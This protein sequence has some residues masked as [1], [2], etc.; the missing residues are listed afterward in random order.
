MFQHENFLLGQMPEFAPGQIFFGEAGIINTIQ[1]FDFISEVLKDA[2]HNAVFAT[3][4]FDTHLVSFF[5]YKVDPVHADISIL[6]FDTL[7]YFYE[8]IFSQRLVEPYMI[9]LLDPE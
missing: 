8:I 3:V 2:T 4:Y 1:A 5:P 6:Q 9:Y 7:R